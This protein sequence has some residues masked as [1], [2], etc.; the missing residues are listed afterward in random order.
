MATGDGPFSVAIGDLNGDGK[1][2]L[3]VAN[4][5]ADT[6]SVLINTTPPMGGGGDGGG[7]FIATAAFGSSLAPQV[8]RLREFRDRYLL[9]N[10][11]GR[12]VVSLYYTLSPPLAD[13][14]A[15]SDPLR[16]VVRV[17]LVPLIGWTTLVM[18]SPVIGLGALLVPVSLGFWWGLSGRKKGGQARMVSEGGLS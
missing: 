14:I 16:A 2:D 9:P 15:R 17:A 18:W 7:C 1:R 5:N 11:A 4:V 6:V 12:G 8:M 10:P 3:A 13:V